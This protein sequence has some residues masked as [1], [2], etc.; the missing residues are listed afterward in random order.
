MLEGARGQGMAGC[1][2]DQEVKKLKRATCASLAVWGPGVEALVFFNA[3]TET[4]VS[5]E[6]YIGPTHDLKLETLLQTKI[7]QSKTNIFRK[8]GHHVS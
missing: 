6:T 2:I 5:T 1:P 3:E 8:N 4:A 7:R